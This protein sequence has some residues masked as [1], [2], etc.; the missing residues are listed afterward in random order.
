MRSTSSPPSCPPRW[1]TPRTDRQTY[2]PQVAIISERL[3]L[4]LMPWQQQVVDV[5]LEIDPD[6]GRLAYRDVVVTVPRQ[7]G[8]TTLLLAVM[9]W[10]ALAWPGQRITY[11]A[12]SGKDARLKWEDDQVPV[13][14]R[15]PFGEMFSV[16][17]TNGSEAIRWRN[18]SL[19]TVISPTDTAGHGTQCDLG[20]VDEAFHLPDH[21]LEQGLKPAMITRDQPQ[22]WVISTAGTP[23]SYYL[24]AKVERGRDAVRDGATSGLAYFEWCA[25][26]EDDPADP[27]TWWRCIPSLGHTVT[28]DAIAAEQRSMEPAEFERAFLNRW[29]LQAFASK[30]PGRSWDA[31]AG[32]TS[33]EP[34]D[35]CFAVDIAPDRSAGS[36]VVC[37]GTTFEL[38][39]RRQGTEWIIPRCIELWDR[40]HPVA[41]VMDGVGPAAA[42]VHELEA[43]GIRVEVTGAQDMASACGRFYDAVVNRKVRHT[44]Q[45]DLT[46]AVA[47]AATRK[48][49]DRWA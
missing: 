34:D 37:D 6:T 40:Y 1:A 10:R 27:R 20:V 26:P 5:A 35:A 46:T 48:L 18:G 16:R 43:A 32:D 38:A 42:I 28:E 22:L 11:T 30:I 14:E 47:G 41:F 13:L 2:G 12:Q 8:K 19:H 15:S 49:G 29:T 36:I 17:K 9:T 24:K 31:C 23:S 33:P 3:G 7:A 44:D 4:P 25:E 45:A 21:R 39:D